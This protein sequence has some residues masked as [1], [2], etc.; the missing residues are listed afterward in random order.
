MLLDCVKSWQKFSQANELIPDRRQGSSPASPAAICNWGC[1]SPHSEPLRSF[2]LDLGPRLS[3]SATRPGNAIRWP[4]PPDS[5]LPHE[6]ANSR[7]RRHSQIIRVGHDDA[8]SLG[9]LHRNASWRA[10]ISF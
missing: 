5:Q 1:N 4:V 9:Y 3:G 7:L 10:I 8:A 2:S 6:K